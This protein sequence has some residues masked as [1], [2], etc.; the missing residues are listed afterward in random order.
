MIDA[1]HLLVVTATV[2][3]SVETEWNDWYDNFHLPEIT[4]CPGFRSSGR[5]V[6]EEPGQERRYIAVYEIVGPAALESP[7]F[8][9]RRGWDR[10]KDKVRFE[11]RHYRRIA[12]TAE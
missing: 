9:A 5:Y 3:E 10:F 7:A 8:A 4:G 12:K 11:T 2:D 6:S 1:E